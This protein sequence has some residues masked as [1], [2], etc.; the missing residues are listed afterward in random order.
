MTDTKP[1]R[2]YCNVAVR[3]W[4]PTATSLHDEHCPNKAE[5]EQPP[6]VDLHEDDET[7]AWD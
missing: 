5:D 4:K 6:R 2:C 3:E 7:V 1:F